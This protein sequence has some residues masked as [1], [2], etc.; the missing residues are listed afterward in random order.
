MLKLYKILLVNETEKTVQNLRKQKFSVLLDEST[1]IANDKIFCVLVKYVSPVIKKCVI[2][3]LELLQLDATGCSAE[4]LYSAFEKCFKDKEIPL[5]N[6]I[7]IACDNASVM[8]GTHDS[9]ISRLKREIPTLII[10]KCICH[11]SALCEYD[12]FKL[13][14][15]C[16]NLLHTITTYISGSAKRSAILREFQEFFG[17]ESRKILKLSRWYKM[18]LQKYITRLLDNWEVLKYYFIYYFYLEIIENK[19]KFIYFTQFIF[20]N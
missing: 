1:D 12:C 17:V 5:N 9:F 4:K 14:G 8:I 3:L 20:N 19:G 11:A 13:P 18:V 7:E 2:E 16:K 6:I 15:S 10:L